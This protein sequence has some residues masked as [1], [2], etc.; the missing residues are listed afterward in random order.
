MPLGQIIN[1]QIEI[2]NVQNLFQVINVQIGIYFSG[3]SWDV[4]YDSMSIC[5][6]TCRVPMIPY[7]AYF[8]RGLL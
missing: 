8:R 2:G 5:I 6:T 7:V 1:V 4:A 3:G